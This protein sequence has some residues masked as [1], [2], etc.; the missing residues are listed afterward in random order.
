[1]NNAGF[2]PA[3]ASKVPLFAFTLIELL[4]VIAIIAILA[5]LLL[6]AL[7]KAKEKSRR[8]VCLSNLRQF[9]QGIIL[10]ADDNGGQLPETVELGGV[11]RRPQ[12][13]YALKGT[14][15]EFF[16]AEA[17][18]A[19]IS[20][21]RFSSKSPPKLEIAGI[22][23]CPSDT[24]RS[25]HNVQQE[26]DAWAGFSYSYSFF[27]RVDNWL[28]MATRPQDL[29]EKELRSDRLLMSDELFH[30]HV[31]DSWTYS[32]GEHGPRNGY[33]AERKLEI[34]TPQNLAGLNQLFGDGRVVWKSGRSMNRSA[35]TPSNPSAGFVKAYSTDST[36]Y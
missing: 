18:S 23:W 17:M 9:G 19:Y 11:N 24:S 30:W 34:G 35:I 12:F 27:A 5:A 1:M 29:T 7:A 3:A 6:P 21:I 28:A 13:T 20:G 31:N 15:P 14:T 8:T 4:V 16:N 2:Q 33:A 10:Y 22:W 25:S 32:H 26:V 36:F